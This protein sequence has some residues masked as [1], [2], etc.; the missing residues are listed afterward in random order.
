M[1]HKSQGNDAYH[2]R[3]RNKNLSPSC[4]GEEVRLE[5]IVHG[6]VV[7]QESM[8]EHI[9]AA[10]LA[11]KDPLSRIVQ[12]VG[13][14]S[15]HAVVIPEAQTKYQMLETRPSPVSDP[16]SE[17]SEQPGPQPEDQPVDQPAVQPEA[18]PDAQPD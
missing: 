13:V 9:A 18:Q 14:A 12:E 8:N 4:H 6:E 17:P 16:S 3:D 2:C 11:E 1:D 7:L 10:H 15:G 5:S